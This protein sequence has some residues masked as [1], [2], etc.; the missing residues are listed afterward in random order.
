MEVTHIANVR[1][2]AARTDVSCVSN[3]HER[4]V[5]Q[6]TI[7]PSIAIAPR[8]VHKLLLAQSDEVPCAFEVLSLESSGGTESP[9]RPTLA[10]V[11]NLCGERL[12][13]KII[14]SMTTHTAHVRTDTTSMYTCN[15]YIVAVKRDTSEFGSS[16][17]MCDLTHG[18]YVALFSPIH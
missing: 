6:T 9:T 5:H 8:A 10:L 11:L 4:I 18:G 12:H 16:Y 1:V 14:N 2:A 13:T 7:A 3:I 15:L 17:V